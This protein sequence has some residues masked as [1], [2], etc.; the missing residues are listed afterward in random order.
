VKEGM[1]MSRITFLVTNPPGAPTDPSPVFLINGKS[2][3][4]T[5]DFKW[6]GYG[7][8]LNKKSK[9]T[10]RGEKFDVEM[11]LKLGMPVLSKS[12]LVWEGGAKEYNSKGTMLLV[13]QL[14]L[15]RNPDGQKNKIEKEHINKL[16]LSKVIWLKKGTWEDEFQVRLPGGYYPIGTGGHIDE[17]CRFANDST[18]MLA[19]VSALERDSDSIHAE[20]YKKGWRKT[21]LF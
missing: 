15:Q 14:E 21:L 10:L 6:N 3:L 13:E 4:A 20:N 12:D 5:V 1:N 9:H 2:E 7:L 8:D 18:I 17:F 11:A 19:E 16:N